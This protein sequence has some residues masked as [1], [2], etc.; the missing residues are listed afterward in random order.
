[1]DG[2]AWHRRHILGSLTE[3][4]SGGGQHGAQVLAPWG[5]QPNASLR[6]ACA[7]CARWFAVRGPRRHRA[8]VST[9]TH[10][11]RGLLTEGPG[12][13]VSMA[14]QLNVGTPLPRLVHQRPQWE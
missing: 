2:S 11:T 7:R 6:F 8:N 10:T 14:P 1:M 12:W 4:P 5:A 9:P 3:S 13:K